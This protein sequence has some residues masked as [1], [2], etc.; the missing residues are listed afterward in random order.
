[1]SPNPSSVPTF[2]QTLGRDSADAVP[3][4]R[5]PRFGHPSIRIRRL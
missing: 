4:S 2:R 1:M 3:D 5:D